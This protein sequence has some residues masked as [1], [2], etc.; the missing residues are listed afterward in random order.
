MS[1]DSLV[2][3]WCSLIGRWGDRRASAGLVAF[4]PASG[5]ARCIS[6]T[7]G[8]PG[9]RAIVMLQPRVLWKVHSKDH[10]VGRLPLRRRHPSERHTIGWTPLPPTREAPLLWV[11]VELTACWLGC[12]VRAPRGPRTCQAAGSLTGVLCQPAGRSPRGASFCAVCSGAPD[13]ARRAGVP[14]PC[15]GRPLTRTHAL[16]ADEAFCC[17]EWRLAWAGRDILSAVG[18]AST[19]LCGSGRRRSRWRRPRPVCAWSS[20]SV[21]RTGPRRPLLGA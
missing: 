11:M 8:I 2:A 5:R 18:R 1:F 21:R 10:L 14:R 3:G 4:G 19:V 7:A 16:L 13:P 6:N 15:A 17:R 20:R 9:A 12:S